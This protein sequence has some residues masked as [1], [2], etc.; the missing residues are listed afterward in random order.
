MCCYWLRQATDRWR[1][2]RTASG[3]IFASL[4]RRRLRRREIKMK[5]WSMCDSW[6]M[7]VLSGQWLLLYIQL[8]VIRNRTSS[9]PHYTVLNLT[10]CF[11]MTLNQIK[12]ENQ[13]NIS[14]NVY[15]IEEQKEKKRILPL[16]LIE[17]EQVRQFVV[18]AGSANW[19]PQ[20]DIILRVDKGSVPPREFTNQ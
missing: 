8:E 1:W 20:I 2:S 10:D 11:S 13:N 5:K 14:I 3:S 9:Y 6:T 19:Y 16:W 4:K 12:F 15:C 7:Y 17:E 18:R